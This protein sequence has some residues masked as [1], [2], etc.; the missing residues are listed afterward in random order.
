MNQKF[1]TKPSQVV[2]HHIQS[3]L[4]SLPVV[5]PGTSYFH[6]APKH[7][8]TSRETQLFWRYHGHFPQEFVKAVQQ[9]LPE[10]YRFVQYDHLKNLLTVEVV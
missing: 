6:P 2:I 8:A 5:S 9:T 3:L 7:Q 4:H 1:T 10:N